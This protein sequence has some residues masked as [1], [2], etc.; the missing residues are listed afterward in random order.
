MLFNLLLF[1]LKIIDVKSPTE[2]GSLLLETILSEDT[3]D[4][5]KDYIINLLSDEDPQLKAMVADCMLECTN[6]QFDIFFDSLSNADRFMDRC[7]KECE[8]FRKKNYSDEEEGKLKGP[9]RKACD[10][11]YHE[12]VN[13]NDVIIK[14][15]ERLSE[16][17]DAKFKTLYGK[18]QELTV[19]INTLQKHHEG[20][21]VIPHSLTKSVPRGEC[22]CREQE[23]Q[24]LKEIL[25]K[26][27]SRLILASGFGGVGKTE[28]AKKLYHD[29]HNK[30]TYSGWINYQGNLMNSILIDFLWPEDERP[31]NRAA[32]IYRFFQEN[33]DEKLLVIDNVSLNSKNDDWLD[34]IS[35]MDHLTVLITSRQRNIAHYAPYDVE[36]LSKENSI[37]LFI[38]YYELSG[39]T[40]K[41]EHRDT[42]EALVGLVQNHTLSVEILAKSAKSEPSLEDFLAHLISEGFCY[43]K[44]RVKTDYA[45]ESRNMAEYLRKL[46]DLSKKTE[47][48]IRVLRNFSLMPSIEIPS[49]VKE[50]INCDDNTLQDLCDSGWLQQ[51]ERPFGY[52][53]HP[54]IKETILL[55]RK[56]RTFP[57]NIGEEFLRFLSIKGKYVKENETYITV[58]PKLEIADNMLREMGSRYTEQYM[59]TWLN[60]AILFRDFSIYDKSTAC[61]NKIFSILKEM[62]ETDNLNVANI[63][64]E[65]SVLQRKQG[66]FRSA[67]FSLMK[68]LKIRENYFSTENLEAAT[69][70]NNIGIVDMDL[71]WYRKAEKYYKR[72]LSIREEK[73]GTHNFDTAGSY[74]N[75]GLLYELMGNYQDAEAYS[76][77]ALEIKLA[78]CGE[79][80]SSTAGSYNNL[81][82]L[83][84][85]IKNYDKALKYHDKALDIRTTVYGQNHC[86]TAISYNNIG[87]VYTAQENY[88]DAMDMF[89]KAFKIWKDK[90]EPLHPYVRNILALMKQIF[91]YTRYADGRSFETWMLEEFNYKIEN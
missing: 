32:R 8:P 19:L 66:K 38:Y 54:L 62:G 55:E 46:F 12:L 4:K 63:Y 73:L 31:A 52:Y 24:E 80:N 45:K 15:V 86:D 47:E 69:L 22:L 1:I 59:T 39:R 81:G 76:E 9:F 17:S 84:L 2:M 53:L 36:F 10:A 88:C 68:A 30:Y 25:S 85:K 60:L 74:N 3:K 90:L 16:N 67:R 43:P 49:E 78:V 51:K 18:L 71:K 70:Y 58:L 87:E 5:L 42:I 21:S 65:Y 27:Q 33:Q 40:Y 14:V 23:I 75:L 79:V 50:W 57:H 83:Y 6:H 34:E 48:E 41:E 89:T 35:G 44:L 37:N 11:L 77:K 64:N 29:L 28:I 82:D 72:A 13:N 91:P 56:D 20:S 7:W 61:F 26:K